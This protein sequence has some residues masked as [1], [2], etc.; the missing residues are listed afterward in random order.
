MDP[1][2][3]PAAAPYNQCNKQLNEE[4]N[5]EIKRRTRMT[6]LFPNV[7]SLL[8]L[9]SAVLTEISDDWKTERAYLNMKTR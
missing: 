9:A 7:A 8:H 4:L 2:L 5:E 6:T 3:P 1:R